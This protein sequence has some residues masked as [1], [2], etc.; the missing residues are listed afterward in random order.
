M[1]SD[2]GPPPPQAPTAVL[3][4]IDIELAGTERI[5]ARPQQDAGGY[6]HVVLPAGTYEVLGRPSGHFAS[7]TPMIR[8]VVVRAGQVSHVDLGIHMI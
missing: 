2:G 6:F 3:G 1:Y 7:A 4:R 5:V 8:E